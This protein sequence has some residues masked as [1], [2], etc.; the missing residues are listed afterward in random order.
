[1]NETKTKKKSLKGMTLVEII[2]SL[3]VVAIMTVLLVAAASAV[4]AYIR[5]SN[6]VNKKVSVQAPIAESGYTGSAN[7]LS[8][9]DSDIRITVNGNVEL[10][11]KGYSVVD[12]DA[13]IDNEVGGN[14]NMKFVENIKPDAT[15]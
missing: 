13:P 5:S 15:T 11:G 1:M 14:L 4:N 9:A 2:I 3:A 12:P 7:E 8:T 10:V 6:N